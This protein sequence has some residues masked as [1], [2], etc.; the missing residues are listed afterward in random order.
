[1]KIDYRTLTVEQLE[2]HV[3]F[4]DWSIVP[5][6]LLTNEVQDLF[7]SIQKLRARLWFEDLLSKMVIKKN[8]NT[9]TRRV[10]FFF[11]DK[12]YM[13]LNL[14]NKHL[15]CSLENIW[16]ILVKEYGFDFLEVQLFIKNI[17]EQHLV[18][19][20]VIPFWEYS[21]TYDL[22]EKLYV[23]GMRTTTWSNI[24]NEKNR[25]I[26]IFLKILKSIFKWQNIKK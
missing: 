13:D 17:I 23:K 15:S 25:R 2:E 8:E 16:I 3:E 12:W 14:K 9:L 21:I 7:K 19:I 10:F 26:K 6:H 11:E 5:S 1:M 24:G 4:I 22:I 18:E 20:K